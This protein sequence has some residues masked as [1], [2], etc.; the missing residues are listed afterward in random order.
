MPGPA[1]V[2]APGPVLY[3]IWPAVPT[4]K[5]LAVVALPADKPVSAVHDAVVPTTV[6]IVPGL[7]KGIN[8]VTPE[9]D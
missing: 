1:Q 6:K 5:L 7:P 3:G 9:A 2:V 4:V 8:A